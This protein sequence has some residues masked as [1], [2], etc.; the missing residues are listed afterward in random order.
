MLEGGDSGAAIVVGDSQK[1][2]L[3][4]LVAGLDP[5]LVMPQK[6]SRL[7][8]EQIGLLRAWIDQGAAW[9]PTVSFAK[10]PPRNIDPRAPA[11]PPMTP[12]LAA[13]HVAN[14][15]DRL[16]A[17][18]FAEHAGPT[19]DRVVD[20]RQFARRVYLDA[21]GLL[22]SPNELQAFV[23]DRTPD[24]RTRLVTRLLA[25]RRKY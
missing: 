11:L 2:H 16:L 19:G 17:P 22:P 5:D 8:P 6:G 25:D 7:K 9:D 18:Y 12:Q 10:Q 4:T 13:S 20:D 3:I 14:P 23:A 15:I 1:S 24:K 21:I